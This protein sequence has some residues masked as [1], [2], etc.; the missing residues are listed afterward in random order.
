MSK[1]KNKKYLISIFCL[2]LVFGFLFANVQGDDAK[3]PELKKNKM[4]KVSK[5]PA[6]KKDTR[7][8]IT[9]VG[10][11]SCRSCCHQS[12]TWRKRTYINHCPNCKHYGT[13][14]INPKRVPER[15]LTC[16]RCSSDFCICGHDKTSG[17][18]HYNSILKKA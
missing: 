16:S 9:F 1:L 17:K 3:K 18:R 2:I 5:K 11:P 13:L 4:K 15:E 7:P 10:K 14:R 6:K 12:Y 8:K